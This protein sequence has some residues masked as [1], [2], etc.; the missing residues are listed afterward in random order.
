MSGA[1]RLRHDHRMTIARALRTAL[2][3]LACVVLAACAS[4]TTGGSGASAKT[5]AAESAAPVAAGAGPC[6]YI[7]ESA[8]RLFGT[9]VNYPGTREQEISLGPSC[10]YGIAV[11]TLVDK[12]VSAAA[13]TYGT[14][15]TVAGVGDHAYYGYDY[16]WLHVATA[17]TRFEIRC[18]FCDGNELTDMT[19]VAKSVVAR[20]S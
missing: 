20:I 11:F 6:A 3:I 14:T 18:R 1:A 9:R 12:D 7:T 5:V 8:A 10:D 4:S 15:K 2:A 16:H 17:G 13:F 19:A